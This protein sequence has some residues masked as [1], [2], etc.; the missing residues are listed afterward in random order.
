M[1]K[2]KQATGGRNFSVGL[3]LKAAK[4][5]QNKRSTIRQPSHRMLFAKDPAAKG[6]LVGIC[7]KCGPTKGKRGSPRRS[8]RDDSLHWP[9]SLRKA[10][11]SSPSSAGCHAC[12]RLLPAILSPNFGGPGIFP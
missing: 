10:C 11:T 2:L 8:F 3:L 7:I 6:Q 5:S 1:E 9:S 4:L 12:C